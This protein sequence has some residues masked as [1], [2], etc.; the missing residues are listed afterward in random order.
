MDPS[1]ASLIDKKEPRNVESTSYL[2]QGSFESLAGLSSPLFLLYSL[3]LALS[4]L[5]CIHFLQP[6][7]LFIQNLIL[8]L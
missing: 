6:L 8:K 1:D 2:R 7:Q 4:L 5:L 3:S